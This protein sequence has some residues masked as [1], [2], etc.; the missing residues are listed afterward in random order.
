MIENIKLVFKVSKTTFY[1]IKRNFGTRLNIITLGI[2]QAVKVKSKVIFIP[3]RIN[4]RVNSEFNLYYKI[5]QVY[6][7]EILLKKPKIGYKRI[8]KYI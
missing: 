7:E 4:T 8:R 6:R 2:P 1:R 3:I 5:E